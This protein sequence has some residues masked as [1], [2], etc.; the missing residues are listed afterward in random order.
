L[1]LNPIASALTYGVLSLFDDQ[2]LERAV[3][4]FPEWARTNLLKF[5]SVLQDAIE[6][7]LFAKDPEIVKLARKT[8]M[9]K[10]YKE[11]DVIKTFSE[12]TNSDKLFLSALVGLVHC[13]KGNEWGLKLARIA[14]LAGSRF[15][16][17]IGRLFDE[18]YKAL[19][20]VSVENCITDQVLRAVYKLY[21]DHV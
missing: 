19:E 18:L 14:A 7:G 21:Y 2:Y 6:I 5:A 3:E 15:G 9:I 1:K 16:G 8:L 13:K 4:H 12:I 20:G 17:T 10:Y 11:E